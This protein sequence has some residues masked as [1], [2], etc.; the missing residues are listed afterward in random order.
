M[1]ND[2]ELIRLAAKAAGYD[3]TMTAVGFSDIDGTYTEYV[4]STNW[5]AGVER[6]VYWNP[7]MDEGDALRLAIQIRMQIN[8][9]GGGTEAIKGKFYVHE[10]T[11]G[12]EQKYGD[13]CLATRRAIVR[14]AA[15]IGKAMP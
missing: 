6:R 15:E 9:S 12:T 3:K 2:Q 14:L 10:L 1:N 7:L 13:K 8:I 11:S 4:K 5:I